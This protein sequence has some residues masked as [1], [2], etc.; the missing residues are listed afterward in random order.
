MNTYRVLAPITWHTADDSY[1]QGDE[2]DAEYTVDEERSLIDSKLLEIVPRTYKVIGGSKVYGVAVG[3][4]PPTFEQ[5]MLIEPEAALIQG[6]HIERVADVPAKPPKPV[7]N[8]KG[9]KKEATD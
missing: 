2:F 6:G 7:A 9:A 1:E 5:A 3:D 4:D 8:P